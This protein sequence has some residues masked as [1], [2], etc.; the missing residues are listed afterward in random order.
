M[1]FKL[2]TGALVTML[3]GHAHA[4][5]VINNGGFENDGHFVQSPDVISDWVV[6]EEGMIGGVM[7]E[8]GMTSAVS[9]YNTV[10]PAAGSHYALI[11]LIA[12]SRASL[13]QTF[14]MGAAA[15]SAT[16]SF[17]AF[18]N[19][20][21]IGSETHF[22]D[23]ANGLSLDVDNI[24]FRVDLMKSGASTFSTDAAD[25]MGSIF[26]SPLLST[27]P[28]AYSHYEASFAG[29]D[30]LA[31]QSYTLRIAGVNTLGAL[32]IGVDNVALNVAA[33]PEPESLALAFAGLGL[34]LGLKTRRR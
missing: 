18:V 33:V 5:N 16:V 20:S 29:L 6:A 27:G 32:Q 21:T 2:L 13:A 8:S 11:D 31:G 15:A 14:S 9:G 12:P 3:V 4:A 10:G 23:A 25:V 1:K 30:L 24:Q 7:V 17:D 28:N 19:Y 22:S 26:V 34:L